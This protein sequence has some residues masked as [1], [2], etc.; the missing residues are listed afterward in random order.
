MTSH[1]NRLP[2][3]AVLTAVFTVV[4]GASATAGCTTTDDGLSREV[5][6]TAYQKHGYDEVK[7]RAKNLRAGMTKY[8]VLVLL[9][10]PARKEYDRWEY[11][12]KQSA[13]I[14]PAEAM[15][16]RFEGNRYVR[17]DFAPIVLG[18]QFGE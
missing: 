15:I 18:E 10:S 4:L 12:P 11:Q 9:G 3:A 5:A 17:H 13:L 7:R 6:A 2:I 1:A 14:V 8:D 16:V